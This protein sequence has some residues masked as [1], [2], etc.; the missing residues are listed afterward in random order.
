MIE[1]KTPKPAEQEQTKRPSYLD[2][3]R[4]ISTLVA[5]ASFQHLRGTGVSVESSLFKSAARQADQ[6]ERTGGDADSQKEADSLRVLSQLGE[7]THGIEAIRHHHHREPLTKRQL[8][9]AKLRKIAF[10][11][12]V[13]DMLMHDP[14]IEFDELTNF[15]S[16]MHGVL[17]RHRWDDD[18]EAWSTEAAWFRQEIVKTIHG[19]QQEIF[20]EQIASAIAGVQV[21]RPSDPREDL[22]GIDRWVTMDGVRF[23][24][25]FKASY[26]TARHARSKSHTPEHV[27]YTGVEGPRF[28]KQ[29]R[30]D[31]RDI[32]LRIEQMKRSLELAKQAYLRRNQSLGYIAATY[33]Q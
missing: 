1:T 16:T 14:T 23:P 9:A 3:S 25:D 2:A 22:R 31:A 15:L 21:E 20:G 29:L 13:Q 4:T 5:S 18:H 33:S 32:A 28:H 7:F 10:N 11:H 27:V 8:E 26:A 12:T 19:M 6:Y 17:N 30:L 24:V